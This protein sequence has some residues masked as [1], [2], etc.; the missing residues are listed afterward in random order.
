MNVEHPATTES[1]DDDTE[2]VQPA[3]TTSDDD[4]MEIVGVEA[5]TASTIMYD[6]FAHRGYVMR[7]MQFYVYRRCA[8][9]TLRPRTARAK[10]PT[11]LA[12]DE[13]CPLYGTHAHHVM[14]AQHQRSNH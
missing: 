14:P 5:C 6:D 1:D 4:D 9:S 13:H 2:T 3:N 12:S 10:G 11:I 7:C 8:R